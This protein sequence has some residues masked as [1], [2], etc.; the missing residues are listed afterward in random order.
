MALSAGQKH[1]LGAR[2]LEDLLALNGAE[3]AAGGRQG[4]AAVFDVVVV[5]ACHSE[6]L[7][8]RFAQGGA[9]CAVGC[10]GPL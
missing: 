9:S 6:P 7:A 5:D 8:Q 4:A 3:V 10:A 1:L 2:D